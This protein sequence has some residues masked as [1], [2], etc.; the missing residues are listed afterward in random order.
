MEH[1]ALKGE[2]GVEQAAHQNADEQGGVDLLG[3]EGQGDGDDRG[4]QGRGGV[5]EIAGGDDIAHISAVHAGFA[6]DGLPLVGQDDAH[7]TAVGALDIL[8]AGQLGGVAPGG[9][10]GADHG[11]QHHRQK[12]E[13]QAGASSSSHMYSLLNLLG[14]TQGS[15][16]A[17]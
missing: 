5:E 16:R 13:P 11:Q 17:K 6:G 12:D 7:R 3:D 14:A 9:E 2:V 10:G 1:C 4:Q 8:G 15:P